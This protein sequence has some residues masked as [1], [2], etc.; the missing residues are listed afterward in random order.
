MPANS[1]TLIANFEADD[2][3]VGPPDN[4]TVTQNEPDAS[5]N[6]IPGAYSPDAI[7]EV[8]GS[9]TSAPAETTDDTTVI[10]EIIEEP[11]VP[12][13]ASLTAGIWSLFNLIA[14]VLAA[15]A[16]LAC[17]AAMLM[18]RKVRTMRHVPLAL[19]LLFAVALVILFF[20][21]QDLRLGMALFDEWSITFA[22]GAAAAIL[23]ASLAFGKRLEEY[24]GAA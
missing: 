1:V 11:D 17:A 13:A 4:P 5:T 24:Q 7:D 14:M 18:R 19:S 3:P 12:L 21:T 10:E 20:I 6:Y 8:D 22:V 23:A 15:A 2:P 9:D 16:A